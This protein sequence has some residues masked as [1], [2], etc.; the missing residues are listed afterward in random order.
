[1]WESLPSRR[2]FAKSG[3]TDKNAYQETFQEE[4]QKL[5]RRRF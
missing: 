1:M 2:N 3:H 5:D 4:N